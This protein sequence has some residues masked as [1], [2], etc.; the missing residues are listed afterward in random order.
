MSQ[1]KEHTL[2]ELLKL[3]ND[4]KTMHDDIK[5]QIIDDTK[6][7]DEL[8][9]KVNGKIDLLTFI[10]KNYVQIIDELNNRDAIR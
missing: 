10:E 6:I 7:I 1:F 4:A 2:T 8:T 5:Q 3:A 9:V